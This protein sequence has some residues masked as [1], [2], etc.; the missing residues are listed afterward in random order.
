MKLLIAT[1]NQNK[2]DQFREIFKI[3]GSD[4]ELLSL[5]DA[6]I[7]DDVKE[8]ADTLIGNA[9]KKALYFAKKSGLVSL[10]D[11]TGLFVDALGG[12]PGL[13]S[14]R[15]HKG[16]DF[17]RCVKLQ[18]KLKHIPEKKR[19]CQ[20]IGALVIY[21]P[22]INEFFEF[23]NSAKGYITDDFRG[24]ADFGYDKIFHSIYF[25]KNYAELS[26]EEKAQ[27]SHRG[28]GIKK[29]LD[30]IKKMKNRRER[31][32]VMVFGT[33][34]IFHLGHRSFLRQAKENGDYLTVVVARDKTVKSVKKQDTKN[35]E[36]A[37][38]ENVQK[39]MLADKVVLGSLGDKYEVI[40]KYKPDVICLGYDQKFFIEDL[41]EKLIEFGL[42]KTKIIRLKSYKPGV[43]KSSKL[44]NEKNKN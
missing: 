2:L 9:K 12:A 41:E 8:D 19:T 14:K 27:I 32:K 20:Y 7:F 42:S 44:K 3:Y 38:L 10:S 11:D 22:E 21:N 13:H 17:D 26:E 16:T 18:E 35:K 6:E 33:F 28:L 25:G 23:E 43:Y 24:E 36:Q 29:Y 30:S 15:W 34:D 31:I 39:S 37:R 40:K 4:F 1:T 5:K